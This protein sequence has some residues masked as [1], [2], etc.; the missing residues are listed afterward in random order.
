MGDVRHQWE[1]RQTAIGT[2]DIVTK[3]L[4]ERVCT[5]GAYDTKVRQMGPG[6]IPRLIPGLILGLIP[7]L[8]PGLIPELIPGV[9]PGVILR[10]LLSYRHSRHQ[11]GFRTLPLS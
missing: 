2:F 1:G 5:R 6:L 11:L 3:G 8:I 4:Q 7:E 9:I 10:R